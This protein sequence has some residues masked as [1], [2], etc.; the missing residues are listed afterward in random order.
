MLSGQGVKAGETRGRALVLRTHRKCGYKFLRICAGWAD[1]DDDEEGVLHG[2][3]CDGLTF[4]VRQ[5]RWQSARPGGRMIGTTWSRDWWIAVG[6][7]L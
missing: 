7:R 2:W 6:P 3:V 5:D 1:D 4:E